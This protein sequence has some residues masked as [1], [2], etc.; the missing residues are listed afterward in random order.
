MSLGREFSEDAPPLDPAR[1]DAALARELKEF[2]GPDAEE[3][4][5]RPYARQAVLSAV[6]RALEDGAET[7]VVALDRG[8]PISDDEISRLLLAARALRET[9]RPGRLVLVTDGGVAVEERLARAAEKGGVSLEGIRFAAPEAFAVPGFLRRGPLAQLGI[10]GPADRVEIA[11]RRPFD[12][13]EKIP[14]ASPLA[15]ARRV[16]LDDF[17]AALPR[18]TLHQAQEIIDDLTGYLAG[19]LNA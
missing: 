14:P 9:G 16:R 6:A 3:N 17:L 10:F 4:R 19:L 1:F 8:T 12:L 2:F 5:L 15:R 11:A 7:T 13:S 18:L